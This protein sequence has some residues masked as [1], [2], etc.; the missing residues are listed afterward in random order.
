MLQ[1][2]IDTNQIQMSR[3]LKIA[4]CILRCANEYKP[5][6]AKNTAKHIGDV[7]FPKDQIAEIDKISSH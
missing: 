4:A 3:K 2:M 6:S 5:F 1:R 7:V